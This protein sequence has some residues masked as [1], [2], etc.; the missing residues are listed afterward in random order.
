MH[1]EEFNRIESGQNY[2]WPRYEGTHDFNTQYT[3][4]EAVMPVFEYT[5]AEMGGGAAAM[6]GFFYND[7]NNNPYMRGRYLAADLYGTMFLLTPSQSPSIPWSSETLGFQCSPDSPMAC[8][9]VSSW[10]MLRRGILGFSEHLVTKQLFVVTAAGIFRI[11][12]SSKCSNR[13]PQPEACSQSWMDG[14]CGRE[15]FGFAGCVSGEC[16]S[17][18]G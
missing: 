9:D 1:Q 13:V 18:A 6:G 8:N 3:V 15:E 7:P 14:R 5:H 16:C 17:S 12:D 2:G 11:V 10:Q 4:N